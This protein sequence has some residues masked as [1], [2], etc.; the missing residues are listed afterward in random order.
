MKITLLAT[1]KTREGY[2]A[3]GIRDYTR[4]LRHYCPF[5]IIELPAPKGAQSEHMQKLREGEAILKEIAP[6]DV[7]IV[8][9]ERGK[10]YG[11][12]SFAALLQ[13]FMN[14]SARRLVFVTG[15]PYGF[16]DAVYSR[17]AMRLSLSQMTFS[18]QM[19]RLIF[20][21][22]LYRAFTII[23]GEPYHHS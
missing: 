11:S 14:Q 6:A 9:D 10:Q 23:R 7:V 19:V 13:Q 18:H 8:L 5:E 22:Q 1:G 16:A 17:A 4:R 2:V 12:E 21:E 3:D 20:A 15:G